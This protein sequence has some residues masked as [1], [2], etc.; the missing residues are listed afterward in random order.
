MNARALTLLIGLLWLGAASAA[1]PPD[2]S[3]IENAV[4]TTSKA[5][6]ITTATGALAARG[7]VRCQ[8]R[9]LTLTGDSKFFVGRTQVPFVEFQALSGGAS[10]RFMTIFY[11]RDNTVTRV[12]MAAD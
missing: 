7:C 3:M 4:E 2:P 5:T 1:Q 10:S 6:V 12:V 9:Y 11:R 8:A